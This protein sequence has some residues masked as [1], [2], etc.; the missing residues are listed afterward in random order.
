MAWTN[1]T[2]D[3]SWQNYD[4]AKEIA[5]A[6]NLRL[7]LVAGGGTIYDSHKIDPL[8]MTVHEF[9]SDA[10]L[11]IEFLVGTD[12]FYSMVPA[13]ASYV[14]Q[15][16][17][18]YPYQLVSEVHTD[19]SM[20]NGWRRVPD[21]GTPQ[22]ANWEA[23]DDPSFVGNYG[24][25]ENFDMAGPW[26]FKDLQVTL[27]AM[28]RIRLRD[29]QF[30]N[31]GITPSPITAGDHSGDEESDVVLPAT[32]TVVV[33]TSTTDGSPS[34][35][36]YKCK[37]VGSTQ[38]PYSFVDGVSL[39][40]E[41]TTAS[42]YAPDDVVGAGQDLINLTRG[43]VTANDAGTSA[44]GFL[45]TIVNPAS[46][47]YSYKTVEVLQA[48]TPPNRRTCKLPFNVNTYLSNN[49]TALA[50]NQILDT[51][52]PSVPDTYRYTVTF[53]FETPVAIANL[54]PAVN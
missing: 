39:S 6:I 14:G 11:E 25:I 49:D 16:T 18:P 15:S 23:Y 36:M 8:G 5:D 53:H 37:L 43:A 54:L 4:I 21:D 47:V 2:I 31:Y 51:V 41:A 33:S 17:Y 30:T 19:I 13:F 46:L 32:A 27:A 52:I 35:S 38:D 1:V 50:V 24:R 40:I 12:S 45:D 29:S 7:D 20:Y 42:F 44:T 28:K 3:T 48:A 34:M 10:Q 22:P 26:L 9:V